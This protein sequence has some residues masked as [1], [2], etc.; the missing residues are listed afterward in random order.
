M[1][2][3]LRV[4]WYRLRATFGRR[5]GDVRATFGRRSGDVRPALVLPYAGGLGRYRATCEDVAAN[6]YE[7]FALHHV[8]TSEQ[9]SI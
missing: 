8:G 5:S 7:G 4:S 6:G 2:Q 9:S 1:S 3:V